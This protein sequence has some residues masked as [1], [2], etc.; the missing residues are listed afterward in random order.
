MRGGASGGHCQVPG[1]RPPCPPTK[2]GCPRNAGKAQGAWSAGLQVTES[3]VSPV[4]PSGAW[5]GKPLR[6]AQPQ[7]PSPEWSLSHCDDFLGLEGR[8]GEGGWLL[9]TSWEARHPRN[10]QG[11]P[12][13]A[14]V[15]QVPILGAFGDIRPPGGYKA[16]LS[17]PP[18]PQGHLVTLG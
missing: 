3:W 5:R 4:C 10:P 2:A 18:S 8:E 12:L 16:T 7:V 11:K 17:P 6:C 13:G 1:A 15:H 9:G 14:T